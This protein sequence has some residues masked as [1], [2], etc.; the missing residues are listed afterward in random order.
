MDTDQHLISQFFKNHQE[1]AIQFIE[2]LE[3][4][5]I[6]ELLE[7]LS[8][9]QCLVILSKLPVYKVGKIVATV[10]LERIC[11][12]IALLSPI[13]SQVILRVTDKVVR[14]Q[15]LKGISPDKSSYLRRVLKYSN[16]RVGAHMEADVLT[17]PSAM[18]VERALEL[19]TSK[20]AKVKSHLF[21]L[22]E[23]GKLKGYIAL[24]AL[25]TEKSSSKISTLLRTVSKPAFAAMSARDLLEHWD[26]SLIDLPVID[27]NERFVGTV[28]RVLLSEFDERKV[29][30]DQSALRAGNALGD[31]YLIGLTSLLGSPS[32]S[33]KN[34]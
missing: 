4:N 30:S 8:A 27:A 6:S 14:E 1:K 25:I 21:V 33:G 18:S 11:Q 9:D 34:Q 16:D 10:R 7:G 20:T 17:L 31:L 28:S 24:D 22:D 5:E 2:D 3:V 19:V 12:L 15:I 32:E 13:V 29:R 26:H 23:E